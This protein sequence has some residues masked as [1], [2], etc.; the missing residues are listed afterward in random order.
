MI[1][2]QC[3]LAIY[4][5]SVKAKVKAAVS[6]CPFYLSSTVFVCFEPWTM[7]FYWSTY[8]CFDEIILKRKRKQE[9]SHS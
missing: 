3:G 7:K 9:N 5:L 1:S 8:R 2:F 4:W 6:Y